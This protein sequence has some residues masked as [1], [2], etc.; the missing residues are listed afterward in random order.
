MLALCSHCTLNL[1]GNMFI[2]LSFFWKVRGGKLCPQLP[3]SQIRRTDHILL[4]CKDHGSYCI[5]RKHL[6]ICLAHS[7]CLMT[8]RYQLIRPLFLQNLG[9]QCNPWHMLLGSTYKY[10]VNHYS[11]INWIGHFEYV[12]CSDHTSSHHSKIKPTFFPVPYKALST[13]A[14]DSLFQSFPPFSLSLHP[15]PPQNDHLAFPQTHLTHPASEA[16]L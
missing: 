7:K 3:H 5:K 6:G 2:S 4:F 1:K 13:L 12:Q 16:L 15:L 10:S 9:S 11:D 14:S 8:I